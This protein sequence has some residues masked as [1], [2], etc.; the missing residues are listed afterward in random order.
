MVYAV[1]HRDTDWPDGFEEIL[2]LGNRLKL[3]GYTVNLAA[4]VLASHDGPQY[5]VSIIKWEHS[6]FGSAPKREE[7]GTYEDKTEAA[8]MIRFLLNVV[9]KRIKERN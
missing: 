6:F 5:K 2:W 9:D 8:N 3:Y 1:I 7:I 4:K